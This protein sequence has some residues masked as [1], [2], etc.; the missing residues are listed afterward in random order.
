MILIVEFN[1]GGR[2]NYFDVPESCFHWD[3]SCIFKG[4]VSCPKREKHLSVC[5]SIENQQHR[6]SENALQMR[7]VYWITTAFRGIVR[8]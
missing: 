7:S 2:Y 3:A 8:I 6:G 4:E 5:K 1:H